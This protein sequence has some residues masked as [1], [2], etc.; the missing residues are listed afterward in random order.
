MSKDKDFRHLDFGGKVAEIDT[1]KS[2]QNFDMSFDV[3]AAKAYGRK[4]FGGH[5]DTIGESYVLQAMRHQFDKDAALIAGLKEEIE[6]RKDSYYKLDSININ[7]NLEI[8]ALKA[9][10]ERLESLVKP[11]EELRNL[12]HKNFIGKSE[13]CARL[14]EDNEKYRSEM[15]KIT[16]G[17]PSEWAYS[18]LKKE[19]DDLKAEIERLNNEKPLWKIKAEALKGTP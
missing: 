14:K 4:L 13:E 3:E 1:S 12:Y 11:L 5:R 7:L 18:I 6:S 10:N 17:I 19:R 2:S 15:D 9:E 8:A 16:N